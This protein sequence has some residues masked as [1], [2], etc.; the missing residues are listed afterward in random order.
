ME[1]G[2]VCRRVFTPNS[3]LYAYHFTTLGEKMKTLIWSAIATG[4]L[5]A[6]CHA[7]FAYCQTDYGCVQRC[8]NKG[9]L[10]GLCVDRCTWCN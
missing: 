2:G 7:A 4:I 10:Y 1:D 8:L 6:V 9:N 5:L 3:T